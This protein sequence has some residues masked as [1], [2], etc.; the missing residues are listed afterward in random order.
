MILIVASAEDVHARC[1]VHELAARGDQ[2]VIFDP[3]ELGSGAFLSLSFNGS[4]E[5][6]LHTTQG[7]E[8]R[9]GDVGCVWYRRPRS[10][11]LPDSVLAE[12]DREFGV[13]E[14]STAFA[15]FMQSLDARFVNCID[16]QASCTKPRQLMMA[17]EIGLAIPPTL[18]TND[19]SAAMDFVEEHDGQVIHK[20]MSSP[21]HQLLETRVWTAADSGLLDVLHIA[22]IIL[23]RRIDGPGD[24]RATVFGENVRA[25][26]IASGGG[27][28]PVDSRLDLDSSCLPY[29]V[30]VDMLHKLRLLMHKLNLVF[31][32]IDL[33]VTED[34]E[35]VFLE[36]NPQG[37][38]LYV[39][40]LTGLPLVSDMADLLGMWERCPRS[41]AGAG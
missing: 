41:A 12:E 26:F 5:A 9:S 27:P 32:T 33:K 19:P 25:A 39:E 17:Q 22:P 11:V 28:S 13:R 35:L 8:I 16:A 23:Q 2:A 34:G 30:D 10:A 20:A 1:V 24:I 3:L 4:S 38:F 6:V 15:G 21:R 40:V 14:W 36:V 29:D 7:I 31:G 37:Q 18:I